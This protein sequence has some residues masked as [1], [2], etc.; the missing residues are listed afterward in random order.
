MRWTT[1]QG[2]VEGASERIPT[3]VITYRIKGW[4]PLA[5]APAL[6]TLRPWDR[7]VL[8]AAACAVQKGHS[9][10]AARRLPHVHAPSRGPERPA[11]SV[12]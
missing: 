12:I 10:R 1:V 8:S 6:E 4:F 2:V 3:T 5:S 7:A 9:W 11:P